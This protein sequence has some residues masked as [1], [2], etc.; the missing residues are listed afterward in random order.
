MVRPEA[1]PPHP[2]PQNL[3]PIYTFFG[4]VDPFFGQKQKIF[5]IRY[6]QSDA[7][8]KLRNR[9]ISI[10]VFQKIKILQLTVKTKKLKNYKI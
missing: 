3:A 10:L 7:C 8:I 4:C 6:T 1:P 2:P 5:L 9:Y